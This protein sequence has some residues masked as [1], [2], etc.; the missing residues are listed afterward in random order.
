M[1]LYHYR[2]IDSA[3][4]EI[5][6]GTFKFS[7]VP[8]LNDPIEGYVD[9]YWQGDEPA[10]AGLFRNYIIGL[11]MSITIYRLAGDETQIARNAVPLNINAWG[12]RP[13][14]DEL[15]YVS[16]KFLNTDFVRNIIEQLSSLNLIVSGSQL[17][18]ILRLVHEQAFYI[19]G[20]R[21][22]DTKLIEKDELALV[23]PKI[24]T[25][26]M[27]KPLI[28]SFL[29]DQLSLI[30]NH[31]YQILRYTIENADLSILSRDD[32]NNTQRIKWNKIRLNFPEL[33]VR[34]AKEI[35]FPPS[36]VVCFSTFPNNSVMWGNYACNHKG[37]CLIYSAKNNGNDYCI[38][39]QAGLMTTSMGQGINFTNEHVSPVEYTDNKIKRNFFESLG[40][41]TYEWISSWLVSYNGIKSRF[42]NVYHDQN[43]RETYWND[44]L[45]A[46]FTKMTVWDYEQEYRL[47]ITGA[48]FEDSESSKFI[49]Y[50]RE[51]LTGVIFGINTSLEDKYRILKTIKEAGYD[52]KGFDIRDAIYD[53]TAR[54]IEIIKRLPIS[55][56]I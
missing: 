34:R 3:L 35:V 46:Y 12:Q 33:Y 25:A 55:L 6:K 23:E 43:W 16:E 41:L 28:L 54:K 2:S 48:F 14:H 5:S 39:I 56:T 20:K 17:N 37:V 1:E 29:D 31:A 30:T 53:E 36:Y 7:G 21:M 42:L 45:K 8:E 13:I 15:I 26:E 40:G 27:I 18:L 47:R 44:Y 32:S 24:I 22:I 11:Y 4:S 9:I 38:P 50:S 52:L 10:W 19:C 49:P 51:C